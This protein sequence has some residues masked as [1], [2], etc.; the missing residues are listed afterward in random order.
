MIEWY[1][2][3]ARSWIT[4]AC[5]LTYYTLHFKMIIGVFTNWNKANCGNCNNI[6]DW[7][8]K[9]T[10]SAPINPSWL[11]DTSTWLESS[12]NYV[13]ICYLNCCETIIY[14]LF[15]Q[16]LHTT[17]TSELKLSIISHSSSHTI[18]FLLNF[19]GSKMN[20]NISGKYQRIE[21]RAQSCKLLTS[22][23]TNISRGKIQER[24]ICVWK[25]GEMAK[26]LSF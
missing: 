8:S 9:W 17:I 7:G 1:Y 14:S 15:M 4:I 11:T 20:C 18:H 19:I 10:A 23:L 24:T 12:E 5:W 22:L 2:I 13:T 25:R 16:T 21:F 26:G 6:A 3:I